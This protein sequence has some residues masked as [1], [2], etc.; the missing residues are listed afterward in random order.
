V[1]TRALAVRVLTPV[2]EV[3]R[4]NEVVA[5]RATAA[6]LLVHLVVH[7]PH[8][9]HVEEAA[10]ALWPSTP[11]DVAR[12]RLNVVV[13]RLRRALDHEAAVH[14][15]GDLLRLDPT[16]WD[17][18]LFLLRKA[19]T[20]GAAHGDRLA[21]ARAI[22][23]NLCHAQF[24]YD[25]RLIEARRAIAADIA[26]LVAHPDVQQVLGPATCARIERRLGP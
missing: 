22:D 13:Y 24:P 4:G 2:L 1:E 3:R 11:W 7:H 6:R 20:A 16:G 25:D 10:D 17:V 14:R 23:G 15:T 8:P 26:R 18:D 12:P 9:V 21:A 19:T 5:L